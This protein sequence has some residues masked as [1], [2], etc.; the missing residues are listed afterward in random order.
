MGRLFLAMDAMDI[1][2]SFEGTA[3]HDFWGPYR[4]HP[5]SHSF[6]NGHILRELTF[7]QEEDHSEHAGTMIECLMEI[8]GCVDEA[9]AEAAGCLPQEKLKY[10]QN[11]YD[12]IVREW[13]TCYPQETVKSGKRGRTKQSKTKNLLD[14]LYANYREVLKFMYDFSVPFDNN[15][16][17]RDLRMMKLKEKISGTFRSNEGADHFCRIRSYIQTVK[18]NGLNVFEALKNAL[19]GNPF[20]PQVMSPSE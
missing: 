13:K 15:L 4:K 17:E 19:L 20:M 8:K 12:E 3:V 6:C 5:C 11:R 9:K 1:L 18:K 2:P 14:R 16:A 10:L 7:A